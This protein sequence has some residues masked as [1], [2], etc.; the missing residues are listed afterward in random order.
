MD[1]SK[2][3]LIII[4]AGR[5]GT[6]MLRDC[7]VRLPEFGTWP[8]DEINAIWR[9]GNKRYYCDEFTSEMATSQVK[10]FI[11]Q[12]FNKA[13]RRYTPCQLVEKTCANSLR[14]SFVNAIFPDA[15]YIFLIRDGRDVV[16][17]S[18]KRWTASI[19]FLY[20]LRKAR[21]V[22]IADLPFYTWKYFFNRW[23]R[24]VSPEKIMPQWGPV[25]QGMDK[26]VRRLFLSEVCARQWQRCV[27][28]AENELGRLQPDRV[29]RVYYESFVREPQNIMQNLSDYLKMKTSSTDIQ[30]AVQDVQTHSLNTWRKMENA[31]VIDQISPIIKKTLSDHHYPLQ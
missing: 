10:R 21:F 23:K 29:F 7:L 18:M 13:Q 3:P 30:E 22:P 28:K 14:V 24:L 20:V 17:S 4:G 6:N 1:T 8:C 25:Y 2:K 5:S 26:D 27:A 31:E 11:R 9:H 15:K 19:D 12:Q 16:L